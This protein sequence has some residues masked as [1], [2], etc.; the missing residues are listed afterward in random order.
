MDCLGHLCPHLFLGAIRASLATGQEVDAH[1]W[2]NL[3]TMLGGLQYD[4]QLAR[5]SYGIGT[6]LMLFLWVGI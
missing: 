1:D 4:Y 6:A 2:N 3:L 5:L